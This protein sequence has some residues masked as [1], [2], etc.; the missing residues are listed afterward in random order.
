MPVR[1]GDQHLH[2]RAEGR[3]RQLVGQPDLDQHPV[4]ERVGR[5]RALVFGRDVRVAR[6]LGEGERRL[7]AGQPADDVAGVGAPVHVRRDLGALRV[8]VVGR[9]VPA[10][11]RPEDADHPDLADPAGIDGGLG[12]HRRAAVAMLRAD[13]ETD[14][15]P[16]RR[17]PPSRRRR[18]GC[19]SSAS[20]RGCA[21]PPGP[22]PRPAAD[23]S[24][25]AWPRRRRR[26]RT[27]RRARPRPAPRRRTSPRPRRRGARR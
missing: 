15:R 10:G 24:A 25:R 7:R 8:P 3:W 11:V 4:V 6:E 20:R 14:V 5:H 26:C 12:R 18:P 9:D 19:W 2:R 1:A 13:R 16:R 27:G 17:R 22:P 21:C 23:G